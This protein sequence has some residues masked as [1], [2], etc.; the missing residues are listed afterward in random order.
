ML[1]IVPGVKGAHG[2]SIPGVLGITSAGPPGPHGYSGPVGIPGGIGPSGTPGHKGKIANTFF[3]AIFKYIYTLGFVYFSSPISPY[4]SLYALYTYLPFF[5]CV[6]F[7]GEKGPPGSV[8]FPGLPG[9]PGLNGPVGEPGDV[10]Q[11]G[12]PGPQG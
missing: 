10:G 11:Q 2:D 5:L 9:P 12:F 1:Y 6:C 3:L 7:P 8:G 4:F